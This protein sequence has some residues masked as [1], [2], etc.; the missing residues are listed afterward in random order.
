MNETDGGC[1]PESSQSLY[2][3]LV[4]SNDIQQCA[5]DY[6]YSAMS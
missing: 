4:V 2:V 3:F 6:Q 5:P 1:V